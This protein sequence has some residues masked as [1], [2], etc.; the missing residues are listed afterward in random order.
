MFHDHQST[1]RAS[2]TWTIES[3]L[4]G[5]NEVTH[6]CERHVMESSVF[7]CLCTCIRALALKAITDKLPSWKPSVDAP[8]LSNQLD[9]LY[10]NAMRSEFSHHYISGRK[11]DLFLNI[12]NYNSITL[13]ESPG[14]SLLQPARKFKKQM[15]TRRHLSKGEKGFPVKKVFNRKTSKRDGT[16]R[17]ANEKTRAMKSKSAPRDKTTLKNLATNTSGGAL[18]QSQLEAAAKL[19]KM[20]EPKTCITCK[21]PGCNQS[22]CLLLHTFFCGVVHQKDLMFDQQTYVV[23]KF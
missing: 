22:K 21:S 20:H 7:Q 2:L 23:Y 10:P 11:K 12:P 4:F 6:K 13:S 15:P 16:A 9:S 3:N 14:E 8:T 5:P 18:S 1:Y 19:S 17:F